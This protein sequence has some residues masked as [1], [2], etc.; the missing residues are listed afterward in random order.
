MFHAQDVE[1]GRGLPLPAS[2]GEPASQR[3]GEGRAICRGI[4]GRG[5]GASAPRAGG[6]QLQ[7]EGW[8][9]RDCPQRWC[10]GAGHL[11]GTVSTPSQMAQR[12]GV[13]ALQFHG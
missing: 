1:G 4:L 12:E 2:P 7:G 5:L 11:L 8:E 13:S 9:G 10:R 6:S 3:L